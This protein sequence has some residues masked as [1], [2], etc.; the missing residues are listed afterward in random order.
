[1]SVRSPWSFRACTRILLQQVGA[2]KFIS[3]SLEPVPGTAQCLD[4][5]SVSG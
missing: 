3:S 5:G 4:E 2:D 1:M